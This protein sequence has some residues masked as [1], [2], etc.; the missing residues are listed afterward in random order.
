MLYLLSGTYK[1]NLDVL[2]KLD[3]GLS[4]M[5]KM[6]PFDNRKLLGSMHENL[7]P[8]PRKV[9]LSSSKVCVTRPQQREE[10]MIKVEK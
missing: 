8:L 5:D 2:V 10:L 3:C 7:H 6:T 1:Q 4:G 9:Y